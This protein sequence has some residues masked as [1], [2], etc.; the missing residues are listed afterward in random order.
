MNEWESRVASPENLHI[1][2]F[3]WHLY[4]GNPPPQIQP[5]LRKFNLYFPIIHHC[6]AVMSS[7][8]FIVKYYTYWENLNVSLINYYKI[9][10]QVKKY[11]IITLQ[12]L[13]LALFPVMTSSFSHEETHNPDFSGT[14]NPCFSLLFP[15]YMRIPKHNNL[16]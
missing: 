16:V 7:N 3:P 1:W 10:T 11:K 2:K 6:I 12:K 13:P 8:I 14:Q 9:K 5:Q 4:V 15:I